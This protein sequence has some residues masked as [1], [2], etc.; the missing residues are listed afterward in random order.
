[1]QTRSICFVA[2]L[3]AAAG[4]ATA[5][6]TGP[7]SSAPAFVI[8]TAGGVESV[9]I[10]TTG[11][12]PAG[13]RYRMA[14]VPDGLGAF[15]GKHGTFVLV[16]DHEFGP[17]EGVEREHGATGSFVSK[18]VID[19]R[20]LE[21]LSGEDLIRQVYLYNKDTGRHEREAAAL[22]RL[23][24]ADLAG[25]GAYRWRNYGTRERIF[26]SGEETRPPFDPD[27]GRGFAHV[28]TGRESGKS[29]ELP[30]LGRMAFENIVAN[31]YAQRKTLVWCMDD[32]DRS[33]SGD[34]PAPSE[35]Y[36]YVG[37]KE[38][39]GSTIERAGLTNGDLLG[40]RVFVGDHLVTEESNEFGFGMDSF[41]GE[42]EF[43]WHNFGDVTGIDGVELQAQTIAADC[44]RMQ[45]I[46]DGCWD[47][48]RGHENTFYFCTT[49][50][51]SSNS[52]LWKVTLDDVEHPGEGGTIE[53]LL[54]GDEGHKMFDNICFDRAGNL[55]LQEDVGGDAR[56]GKVWQYDTN[57]GELLE[58][59]AHDPYYFSEDGGGFITTNEEASGVIDAGELIGPGWL[60][61]TDQIHADAG[62]PELV[63]G[64][65]LIAMFNSDTFWRTTADWTQ[66]N[67]VDW[68]DLL[69]FVLGWRDHHP[70]AD[71]NR[72]GAYDAFDIVEY[73]TDWDANRG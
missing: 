66:D 22:N 51:T 55:I 36:L 46:E 42:A 13:S 34:G 48:R 12:S 59:A 35:V 27:H 38:R 11:D 68:R 61:M 57:T 3:I 49:A 64:G 71:Y 29:F 2:A 50:S 65:Q 45:R 7:S 28:V 52:R 25:E 39:H 14:G 26:L 41:I 44:F 47:T 15:P 21:V 67:R 10:L 17:A 60:L 58:I 4:Q 69:G 20:T 32:A 37:E 6:D 23:C 56:L 62:D 5:Q 63:E 72:D 54:K 8:P 33:T 24:S 1:M 31:P 18:W 19:G 40:M 9:S 16:M 70:A 43:R 30:A 73:V 53:I